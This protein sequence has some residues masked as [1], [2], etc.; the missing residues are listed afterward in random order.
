MSEFKPMVKMYTDE[1]SVSLKLKK[2]GKVHGH[3]HAKGG[4]EHGEHGHKAMHHTVA[5]HMHG[6]HHVFESESG[7]AP[8]KPSMAER[9]KA[10][11]PNQYAKGGKVAHKVMGGAMPMQPMG[12][13]AIAGMAPAARAAR[14]LQ[15]R[16]ALT[17]MKKGG[18]AD[19]KLIE[20]LEKELH[21][22]EH[23]PLSKA[24][25]KA[26]GG[27]IDRDE[28]RT[29]IEKGA[30]KFE[31]DLVVDGQHHDKHHG[32]GQIKEGRAGGFKHGGKVHHLSGHEEGSHEHH[33]H[34]AKHHAKLHKETGSAHHKAKAEHHKA[35]CKGG[36]YAK[37][38]TTGERT[39]A[40]TR[41]SYNHGKTKF[42]GTIED[43]EHDYLETDMHSAKRDRASGTGGVAMNNAGGFKHGGKAHH[44]MHHKASGGAIDKG[45]TRNTIEGGDWENRPADT[46]KP[47]KRNTHTG[48]VKESNAGGFKRGGHASKKAYA[49]GGNVVST[50]RAVAMPKKALSQP[51]ANSL[52]SGTF[53]RGGK[54]QHHYDGDSVR[55]DPTPSNSTD[56]R[57]AK[58]AKGGSTWGESTPLRLVK[59]HTGPKGHTAKVYKDKDWGEHRVKFYN[60]EGKHLPDADYHTDDVSDAHDTAR[61]MVERGY[62]HGGKA[63][64]KFESGGDAMQKA[65]TK[66]YNATYAN[67]TAENEADAKAVK[68]ALTY[69]PRKIGEFA[70]DAWNKVT[71]PSVTDSK[72]TVSR[73]VSPPKRDVR[74]A[75]SPE[76]AKFND[77]YKKGGRARR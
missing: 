28:T 61:H 13:A 43:N 60:A 37:G 36:S 71:G 24:H 64:K 40:D 7:K 74:Y 11:N 18:S 27:A 47:G 22:H 44:K 29:T 20:K 3:H 21:H 12:Q 4:S 70:K 5:G 14:A 48:E 45:L 33:K 46:A 54:V 42:G 49:T 30:K 19:H 67:E 69:I 56:Y 17:G 53:K 32:T 51:I 9:R 10:M 62:K 16:K 55:I 65:N 41:E 63:V 34:M 76:N 68:D 39:P 26:S 77:D 52:Q 59:T 1:P 35:M 58:L 8:K 25:H 73:T 6:A 2:G 38:G 50:G 23:L 66:G 75:P 15:V 72:T 57:G 31:K